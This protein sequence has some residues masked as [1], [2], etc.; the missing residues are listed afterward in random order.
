VD[1]HPGKR[2]IKGTSLN[3][4][5]NEKRARARATGEIRRKCL[6][7]GADHLVTL[8]YRDNVEDRERVLTDLERLRC[9][10][11]RGGYSMPYAVGCNRARSIMLARLP[12]RNKPPQRVSSLPDILSR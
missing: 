6:S 4:E 7:I 3:K 10:L 5:Q 11:S 1:P 8:T 12:P 2:A 9:M